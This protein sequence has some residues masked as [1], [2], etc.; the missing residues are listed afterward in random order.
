MPVFGR[1]KAFDGATMVLGSPVV[2]PSSLG[3]IYNWRAVSTERDGVT[4]CETG[5]VCYQG[6][7]RAAAEGNGTLTGTAS[8]NRGGTFT[9]QPLQFTVVFIIHRET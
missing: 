5:W 9:T 3:G 6:Y 2:T 7:F 4:P 8:D 1:A